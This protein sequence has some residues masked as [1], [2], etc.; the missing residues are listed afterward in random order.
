MNEPDVKAALPWMFLGRLPDEGFNG[1]FAMMGRVADGSGGRF[2]DVRPEA[3]VEER[4]L[5]A[6]GRMRTGYLVRYVPRGVEA[7]GWRE[8]SVKINRPGRFD[9]EHRRGYF[10]EDR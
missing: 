10:A 6:L 7:S 4:L 8:V 5:D 3:R 1:Y 9:V 2:Y